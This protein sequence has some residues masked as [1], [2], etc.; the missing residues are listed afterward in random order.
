MENK[1][2][3]GEVFFMGIRGD[4][5]EKYYPHWVY[6]KFHEPMLVNDTSEE[7]AAKLNG[8]EAVGPFILS[9]SSMQNWFWD[10]EDMS[11]KQL[12]VFAK[13]EFAID[14]PEDAR[15]EVL[16]NAVCKLSKLAPQNHGRIALM[17]HTI[18]MN[19]DETLEQIRRGISGG[20]TETFTEEFVA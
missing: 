14:L 4:G 10:L 9:N 6:H 8:F 5:N 7:D 2:K 16:F 18:K 17:A 13:D 3:T 20:V 15:Q 11:P 19:Y 1:K 12:R